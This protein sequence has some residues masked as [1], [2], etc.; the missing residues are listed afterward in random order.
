EDQTYLERCRTNPP[1]LQVFLNVQQ[2]EGPGKKISSLQGRPPG[3]PPII[4]GPP[5]GFQQSTELQHYEVEL[6]NPTD[7]PFGALRIE[8]RLYVEKGGG[9]LQPIRGVEETEPLAAKSSVRF[10]TDTAMVVSQSSSKLSFDPLTGQVKEKGKNRQKD[11]LGGIWIRAYHEGEMVK[12][13]KRLS[14]DLA[15]KVTN[16]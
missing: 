13:V 4:T 5:R 7:R 11:T 9:G 15:R 12:E 14:P 3:P 6:T 8:Y 2:K 10:K 16:F 1:P